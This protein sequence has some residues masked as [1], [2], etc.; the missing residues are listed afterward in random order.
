MVNE[1]KAVSAGAI[2]VSERRKGVRWREG[3]I[4]FVRLRAVGRMDLRRVLPL[5]RRELVGACDCRPLD[6]VSA[7]SLARGANVAL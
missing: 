7:C 6:A 2:V 3:H 5:G 4:W 1:E